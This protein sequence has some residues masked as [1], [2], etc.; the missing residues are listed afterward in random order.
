MSL[1]NNISAYGDCIKYFDDAVAAPRG[2]RIPVG[3]D[4]EAHHLR[5]RLNHAR[6]LLRDEAKRLYERNDPRW[7]KSE[8]DAF[9]VT[10]RD[11]AS[12]PGEPGGWVYIEPWVSTVEEPEEL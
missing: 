8:Y 10:K 11:P 7:G 2:I 6:V 3:S 12:G 9:R 1:P 4:G 5:L